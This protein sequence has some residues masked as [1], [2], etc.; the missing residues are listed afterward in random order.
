M[1]QMTKSTGLLFIVLTLVLL[2]NS[3]PLSAQNQEAAPQTQGAVFGQNDMPGKL[4]EI[5]A[6]TPVGTGKG[7]INP[8]AEKGFAGIPGA[9]KINYVVAF[10]WA[11]WVGW[12]FAT[13]GAFGGIMA[14]V[15]HMTLFALGAYAASFKTSNPELNALLTDTIRAS[16]QYLVG[17]AALIST[18]NFLKMKRLVVPLGAALGIGSIAGG[19][20]I[21]FLTAGKVDFRQYQG[22]FG[23]VVL[24]IGALMLIGTSE[25]S[26][27]KKKAAD[28]TGKKL[29]KLMKEKGETEGVKMLSFSASRISFSF[30]GAEFSFNPLLALLGGVVIASIS[31]FLGVGGGFL[32]VPFLTDIVGLP[33][34]IVAGTSALAVLL[35]MISSIFTYVVLKGTFISWSLVGIEMAGVF[36]GSMIGPHTQKYI[37]EKWLKILFIFLAVYLGIAYFSTGFFGQSWLPIGK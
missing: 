26:R 30:Y 14:G 35:S 24:V 6:K 11:I 25:K 21:P 27:A 9:P 16:N 5:V 31:S 4:G 37:P 33:M 36:V 1:T 2:L 8:Q 15:G 13:V 32:Y 22:W 28:E 34:Y 19:I 17:L 3:P 29:Q 20:L 18:V 10:F 12:I 7:Q 23:I